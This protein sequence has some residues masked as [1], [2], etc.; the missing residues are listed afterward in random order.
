MMCYRMSKTDK[1]HLDKGVIN[2]VD[3]ADVLVKYTFSNAISNSVKLGSWEASLE[4]LIDSIEVN[5]YCLLIGQYSYNT[6]L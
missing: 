3:D 4:K 1:P 5:K 2:I 6:I